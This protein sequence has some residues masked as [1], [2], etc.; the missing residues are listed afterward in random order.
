MGP[1]LPPAKQSV[2]HIHSEEDGVGYSV[3]KDAETGR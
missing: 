1:I 2:N 3:Y